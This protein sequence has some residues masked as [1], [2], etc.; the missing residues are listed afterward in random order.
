MNKDKNKYIIGIIL[1]IS[2]IL[3][4]FGLLIRNKRWDYNS[5]GISEFLINYEGGFIRRGLIGEGLFF[6]SKESGIDPR[7][8]ILI[9]CILSYIIVTA[10]LFKKFKENNLYWWLILTTFLSGYVFDIIRKD[11]ILYVLEII[12]FLVVRQK[13]NDLSKICLITIFCCIGILIHEAFIFFGFPLVL[14]CILRTSGFKLQYLILSAVPILFLITCIFKGNLYISHEIINSWNSILPENPL[15]YKR[16]NSIGAL[17]WD[18]FETFKFHLR[19]NFIDSKFGVIGSLWRFLLFISA[20]YL[21]SN[22]ILLFTKGE[23][24]SKFNRN[25]ISSLFLISAFFLLPMFTILSCDGA[26]IYQYVCMTSFICYL[27]LPRI[28][29]RNVIGEKIYCLTDQINR[30]MDII[31]KPKKWI[32]VV[33]ILFWGISPFYLNIIWDFLCSPVGTIIYFVYSFRF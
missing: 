14:I 25:I 33:L 6:I 27:I 15:Y 10:F 20:Y 12:M 7:I 9:L 4:I 26:R 11:Y 22:Y 8:F 3:K 31:L 30:G 23:E 17:S 24:G 32:V 29:L 28:Y 21:L 5:S 1:I 16:M 2:F 13:L 19:S 18:T